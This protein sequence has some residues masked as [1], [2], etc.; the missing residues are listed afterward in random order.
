MTA[1]VKDFKE[2]L[3]DVINP[4][5]EEDDNEIFLFHELMDDDDNDNDNEN[6]YDEDDNEE[7]ILQLYCEFIAKYSLKL[8][9]LKQINSLYAESQG[10]K[11]VFYLVT[12]SDKAYVLFVFMNGYLYWKETV[13]EIRQE[14]VIKRGNKTSL[15]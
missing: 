6:Y 1:S 7:G 4:V 13:D 3:F 11:T 10:T 2:F 8:Y 12:P 14:Q 9:V 5:Y 15:Q